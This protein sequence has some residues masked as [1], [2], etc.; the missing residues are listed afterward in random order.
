MIWRNK[1]LANLSD[2]V[3]HGDLN[4]LKL[5]V[6]STF[7]LALLGAVVMGQHNPNKTHLTVTPRMTLL[8][9]IVDFSNW[10]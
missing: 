8:P 1:L 5:L 3:I 7:V 2:A 9:V 10:P 4:V 6:P